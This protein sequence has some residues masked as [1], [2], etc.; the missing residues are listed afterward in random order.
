MKL[1]IQNS[2]NET[3]GA[4]ELNDEVFGGR[5]KT[6]LI[7]ASVVQQNAAERRGTHATKNRALV[8]GGGK[9]PY[10]Q[11]G[12]GRP[13]VGSSRTP[14]W[15]KGGTVFGPQPRSYEFDMPKKVRIGALRAALAQKL[16]D[17]AV[18]VVDRLDA[19]DGKTK[20]TAEMLRRLG[21][22]GKTLVIDV[23]PEDAFARSARN[24]AGVSLVSSLRVTP[25][26]II[27][28]A[29]VIA[30]REALE[31]LQESLG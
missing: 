19:G 31:K 2:K 30:T 7:W 1:N 21:A 29:H 13:Q 25:R 20:G 26:D 16:N 11:K 14:L 10:K 4:L 6:D 12:T 22:V 15:R 8:S 27:D 9:K 18:I 5:V 24:I 23:Q 17:G 28:T 3:V